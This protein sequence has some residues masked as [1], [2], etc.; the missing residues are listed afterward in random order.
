MF[1]ESIMNWKEHY[2]ELKIGDKVIVFT[3]C[4]KCPLN[5]T[6]NALIACYTEFLS[7]KELVITGFDKEG[8]KVVEQNHTGYICSVSKKILRKI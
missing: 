6:G 3:H 7:G 8:V 2:S 4:K 5:K 1:E